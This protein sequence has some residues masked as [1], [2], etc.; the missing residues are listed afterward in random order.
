MA[1]NILYHSFSPIFQHPVL[2]WVVKNLQLSHICFI[3]NMP[4]NRALQQRIQGCSLAAFNNKCIPLLHADEDEAEP[5]DAAQYYRAL[6]LVLTGYDSATGVQYSIEPTRNRFTQDR[7]VTVVRDYDSLISFTNW[8]PIIR[9]IY[10]YPVSNP[11]DTLTSN[12]HLKV[13]MKI[14]QHQV[15]VD[16]SDECYLW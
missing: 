4:A 2:D 10:I 5:T 3:S 9:D 6:N 1:C 8:L 11:V 16:F 14:H 15:S 13:P 7:I 12:V